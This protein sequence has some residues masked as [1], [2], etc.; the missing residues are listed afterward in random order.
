MEKTLCLIPA[1][2][3]STRLPRKNIMELGGKTLIQWAVDAMVASEIP[4]DLAV[5][6][7]DSAI[8]QHARDLDVDVVLRP[9]TLAIDPAGVEQVSLHAL[10]QRPGYQTL[11]IL[12]PTSPLRNS[13]D[14]K[15]AWLA[16]HKWQAKRLMTVCEYDHSPY[17]AWQEQG[18]CIQPLH[19]DFARLKSQQLP[20][21]F[22]IN[23]AVT[24]LDVATFEETGS[25]TL[26][27]LHRVIMPRQRSV[28]IDTFDDWSYAQW[29]IQR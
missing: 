26:E 8:A 9:D 5:S 28:D 14:I 18:E 17:S 2:G 3:K 25:Y 24:I 4:C 19:P 10:A 12:L 21:A 1:K 7:E 22:R 13:D 16:F 15:Q 29:L 20:K 6:T 27:P 23:G 11:I